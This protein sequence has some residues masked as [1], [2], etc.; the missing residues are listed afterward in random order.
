VNYSQPDKRAIGWA[1]RRAEQEGIASPPNELRERVSQS[2]L[3]PRE[4]DQG[5]DLLLGDDARTIGGSLELN[6]I[7]TAWQ[8]RLAEAGIAAWCAGMLTLT[9]KGE[10]LSA[11]LEEYAS[12][13]HTWRSLI[14]R[15]ID[16]KEAST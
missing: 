11:L 10:E 12:N 9:P 2:P 8:Y 15:S 5:F 6:G 1:L 16:G 13:R 3:D 7:A 14:F 4:I